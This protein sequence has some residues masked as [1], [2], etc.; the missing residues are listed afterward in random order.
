MNKLIIRHGERVTE[1]PIDD[2][3]LVVGR[4][5]QCDLFF[6]DKKLSR[7]HARF[8]RDGDGIRLVDLGSRNGC[9][10][11]E[12]RVEKKLLTPSDAVR[13][14]SLSVTL[15]AEPEPAERDDQESTV[16]LSAEPPSD[17]SGTMVL[18]SNDLPDAEPPRDA[19]TVI[20]PPPDTPDTNAPAQDS[21]TRRVEVGH[22][23]PTLRKPDTVAREAREGSSEQTIML[24][25]NAPRAATDTGTVIFRGKTAPAMDDATRLAPAGGAAETKMQAPGAPRL[26]EASPDTSVQPGE[27]SWDFEPPSRRDHS[28]R[29]SAS[30][31]KRRTSARSAKAEPGTT[32]PCTRYRFAPKGR[33]IGVA[34]LH[35][36]VGAA[37]S[38]WTVVMLVLGSLLLLMGVAAAV[39]VARRWT[40][41]PVQ[42]LK[43]DVEALRRGFVESLAEDRPY[44]DLATIARNLNELVQQRD[45]D[46]SGSGSAT[47]EPMLDPTLVPEEHEQA[48]H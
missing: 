40:L 14:G 19:G 5:P 36:R 38:R 11:N 27:Q 34:V 13:L 12:E 16:Y 41:L 48:D 37:V 4:D 15:E 9:W 18:S 33:R 20:L 42:E 29:F 30:T 8:E 17:D 45:P 32:P 44:S 6:A 23:D 39:L 3:P 7:R 46:T 31:S 22:E 2:H 1:H 26:P 43:D 25:G 21:T 24:Q 47:F 28:F 10:V 35:Y